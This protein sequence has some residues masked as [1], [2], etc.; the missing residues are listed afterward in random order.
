MSDKD[1]RGLSR[2]D[3]EIKCAM[4]EIKDYYAK[5]ESEDTQNYLIGR[6]SALTEATTEPA[7]VASESDQLVQAP[8]PPGPSGRRGAPGSMRD[9]ESGVE[10]SAHTRT[11]AYRNG[12][13]ARS[14]PTTYVSLPSCEIDVLIHH[15]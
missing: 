2:S 8:A 4:L 6:I 11:R 13:L 14:T 1:Y 12:G 3:L 9:R 10:R 7:P 15:I 5:Q